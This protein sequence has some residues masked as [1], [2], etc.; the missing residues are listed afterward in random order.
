LAPAD[1]A[2]LHRRLELRFHS[3]LAGGFLNEVRVLRQRGDLTSAHSSMRAVGYRQLWAPG[4][5][6][7]PRGS[8]PARYFRNAPAGQTSAH[9][10]ALRAPVSVARSGY[11]TVTVVVE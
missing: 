8:H 10:D 5:R 1:R 3:M 7:R 11:A 4:G 6:I 2:L 9:L